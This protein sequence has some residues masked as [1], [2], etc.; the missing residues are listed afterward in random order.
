MPTSFG[1]PTNIVSQS[2]STLASYFGLPLN[3][4]FASY[5]VTSNIDFLTGMPNPYNPTQQ[6]SYYSRGYYPI[7][8]VVPNT[9]L[10]LK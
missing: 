3:Y 10:K 4:K 8:I 9:S 6:L 1:I 5:Y 7:T 2:S